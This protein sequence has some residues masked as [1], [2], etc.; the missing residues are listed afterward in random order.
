MRPRA[1]HAPPRE[2]DHSTPATRCLLRARTACTWFG[3]DAVNRRPRTPAV[4]T[5]DCA[6]RGFCPSCGGCRMADTAAHLL[7]RVLPEVYEP[8]SRQ[9]PRFFP[10]RAPDDAEVAC[11]AARASDRAAVPAASAPTAAAG[12]PAG[13]ARERLLRVAHR[14]PPGAASAP[15]SES[16]GRTAAEAAPC[17]RAVASLPRPAAEAPDHSRRPHA[18]LKSPPLEPGSPP[19]GLSA[20]STDV[21]FSPK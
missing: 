18:R 11:V 7:D 14:A 10:L 15:L 21:R 19:G 8:G 5:Q 17:S 1:A 9:A 16:S 13:A 4:R 20:Q 3:H 2:R 12:A 6:S